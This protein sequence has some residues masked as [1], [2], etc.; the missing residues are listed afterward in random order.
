MNNI[1]SNPRSRV[2]MTCRAWFAHPQRGVLTAAP[3]APRSRPAPLAPPA[4][5]RTE[6]RRQQRSGPAAMSVFDR[7]MKRRQRKWAASLQGGQQYD[8]LR[9]EVLAQLTSPQVQL[10]CWHETHI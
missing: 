3:S 6:A 4:P 1:V 10:M 7:E 5:Q 2:L 9:D 8:Y